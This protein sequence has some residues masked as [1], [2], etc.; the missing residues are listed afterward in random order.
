[1]TCPKCQELQS[2]DETAMC[3]DCGRPY[4]QGKI[5]MATDLMIMVA[6]THNSRDMIIDR[7]KK[8]IERCLTVK[9]GFGQ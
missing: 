8:E 9:Q 4:Y 5:D 1:M 6:N 2:K 3:S 7:C